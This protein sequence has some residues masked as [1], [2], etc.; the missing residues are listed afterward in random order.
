VND[1]QIQDFLKAL[2]G[3]T[4]RKI[5]MHCIDGKERTVNQIAEEIHINQSTAS[6]HLSFMRRA[7]I[8]SSKKIGKEVYYLPDKDKVIIILEKILAYLKSC[9]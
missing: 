5:L 8:F 9:C 1:S 6:E 4:R 3:D 2:A 7:Q